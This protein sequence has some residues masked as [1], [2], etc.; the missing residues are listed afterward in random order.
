M[1]KERVRAEFSEPPEPEL[2]EPLRTSRTFR[3]VLFDQATV[4]KTCRRFGI[5]RR[6]V[7]RRTIHGEMPDGSE[8]RTGHSFV[9]ADAVHMPGEH[10]PLGV[11]RIARQEV[12]DPL[13]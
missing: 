5:V 4:C 6:Q 10:E 13:I 7:D 9:N 1:P 11:R 3:T 12:S 2:S 8:R